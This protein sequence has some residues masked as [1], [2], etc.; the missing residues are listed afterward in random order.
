M[1]PVWV[2]GRTDPNFGH[3]F[4]PILNLAENLLRG[5]QRILA[6]T[7]EAWRSFRIGIA[8]P[9]TERKPGEDTCES[10]MSGRCQ[11]VFE[12]YRLIGALSSCWRFSLNVS[13]HASIG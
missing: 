13:H 1:F 7:S 10:V 6:N 5:F 2:A 4:Q 11:L 8:R 9:E 3:N 12:D